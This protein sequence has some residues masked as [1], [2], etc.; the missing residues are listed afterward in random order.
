MAIFNGSDEKFITY[1]PTPPGAG[2][3]AYDE[4]NGM[5]YTVDTTVLSAALVGFPW[6]HEK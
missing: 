3:V 4:T 1:V 5:V 2:K 6:P